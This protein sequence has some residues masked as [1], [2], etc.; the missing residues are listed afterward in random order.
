MQLPYTPKNILHRHGGRV[1]EITGIQHQK[2]KPRGGYSRDYWEWRGRVRWED[3][4]GDTSKETHIDPRCLVTD[5]PEGHA[6]I[7]ELGGLLMDYL[8]EHG[9]WF[10]DGKHKGWYAHRK[11]RSA[12]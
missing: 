9:E 2:D 4:S 1:L 8:R 3:G 6:E 7:N 12:A 10:D 5:S 11:E